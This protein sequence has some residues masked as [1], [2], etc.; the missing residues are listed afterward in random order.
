VVVIPHIYD[1]DKENLMS[2]P[3]PI[4][5]S[6]TMKKNIEQMC[7]CPNASIEIMPIDYGK[8]IGAI[9]RVSEQELMAQQ[10]VS[11]TEG[12]PS[13]T[14]YFQLQKDHQELLEK[15]DEALKIIHK[16]KQYIRAYRGEIPMEDVEKYEGA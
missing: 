3:I 2:L 7:A 11:A 15:Y 12:Y 14:Q 16:Q 10:Y 4:G 13:D 6:R 1:R 9:I 8:T 5:Y